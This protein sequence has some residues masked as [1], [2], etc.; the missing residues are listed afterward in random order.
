MTHTPEQVEAAARAI[1]KLH[2]L[3]GYATYNELA[4]AALA[5]AEAAGERVRSKKSGATYLVLT[6]VGRL[7][8]ERPLSDMARLVIYRCEQTGELWARPYSEFMD[9]RFEPAPPQGQQ[10]KEE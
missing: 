7:Q 2:R 3:S 6:P 8:T 1:E 5:A 4:C 10:S 9:G